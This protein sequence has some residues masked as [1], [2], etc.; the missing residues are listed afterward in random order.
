MP[1]DKKTKAQAAKDKYLEK[2]DGVKIWVPKGD[3]EKYK[4]LAAAHGLSLNALTVALWDA[5]Q[6]EKISLPPKD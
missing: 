3:R 1:D 2:M 4:A 5:L 6:A